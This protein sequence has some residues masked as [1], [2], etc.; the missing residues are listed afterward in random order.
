MRGAVEIDQAFFGGR[1]PKRAA[2]AA[3]V[4][5]RLP[6]KKVMVVGLLEREGRVYTRIIS[7]ADKDTL[8]PIIH[9]VL[10]PGT[11][12][13]TDKWRAYGDL[14][15]EGYEHRQVDHSA[16]FKD[17]NKDHIGSIEAFWSFAKRRLAKFNGVSKRT[18][19]LHIKECEWRFNMGNKDNV[20]KA[21]KSMLSRRKV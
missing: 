6:S 11:L 3:K 12:V 1:G 10:E 9:M 18:L 15:I 13:L 14:G 8:M 16:E 19:P 5:H 7:H 2:Y 4:K 20:L 17:R 21:L